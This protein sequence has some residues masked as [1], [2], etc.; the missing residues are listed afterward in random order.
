MPT[1]AGKLLELV[2]GSKASLAA[3]ARRSCRR[4][5]G[6]RASRSP[7]LQSYV[8]PNPRSYNRALV[9]LSEHYELLVMTWLPGQD[10]RAARS[11]GL[12]LHHAGAAGRGRGRLSSASNGRLR[13]SRLR[14]CCPDG[15]NHRGR[16]R[17]RSLVRNRAD[18][19]GPLV[20]LHVYAPP[21]HDFRRFVAA[22]LVSR[23][24]RCRG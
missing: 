15:R 2:D 10:E 5:Q 11:C 14:D 24:R 7:T 18:A 17:R 6:G 13:R 23:P 8:E 19:T 3:L 4:L 12:D 1:P 21:L 22:A 20:T 16:G 9:A